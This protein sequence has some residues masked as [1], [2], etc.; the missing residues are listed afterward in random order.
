M[1]HYS[2]TKDRMNPETG[3]YI[4]KVKQWAKTDLD[5]IMDYMVAEGTGLT[6]PQALAY[7]E[8]LM[9]S[10]EHFIEIRGGITTPL[11]QVRTTISGVFLNKSDM[12]DPSRHS[13]NLRI[14]PGFR[15]KKLKS[16]LKLEKEISRVHTPFPESFIDTGSE[17]TNRLATP[18]SIAVLKGD[19]LKFDPNDPNQGVFFIPENGS[20]A[21]IRTNFYSRIKPSEINFLIPPLPTGNYT[22]VVQAIMRGHKSIRAG[23]LEP[24]ITVF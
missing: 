23:V 17:T 10:I 20:N 4:A 8:K 12:F 7:F 1:I 19:N 21:S 6:R 14:R 2:L 11:F 13:I 9:Q 18:Q 15:L 24:V 22:I 3:G 5:N 16:R